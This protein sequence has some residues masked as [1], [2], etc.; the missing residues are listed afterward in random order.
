MDVG[1]NI[2]KA[3]INYGSIYTIE[4]AY[5]KAR[6]HFVN[7][8]PKWLFKVDGKEMSKSIDLAQ[9]MEVG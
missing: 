6:I 7:Q 1:H 9:L 4:T 3:F 8:L 2:G 5:P